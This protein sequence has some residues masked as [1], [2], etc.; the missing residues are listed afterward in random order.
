M[1][2]GGQNS[3][4][5]LDPGQHG[6][7]SVVAQMHVVAMGMPRIEGVVADHVQ[8]LSISTERERDV[9]LFALPFFPFTSS[10]M[11]QLLNFITL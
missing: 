4:K 2:S 1:R 11:E 9:H 7:V 5:F 3:L 6:Q 8:A 10:G